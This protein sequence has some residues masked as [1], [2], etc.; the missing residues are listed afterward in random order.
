MGNRLTKIYTRTGD[1]GTTGLGDGSRVRKT[2]PRIESIGQV[3]H[4]N[5]L[6]G[7]VICQPGVPASTVKLLSKIQHELFD[8]GAE[9][10]V[11]GLSRIT[12]QHVER[13][14]NDL[15]QLNEGLGRLK[16]FIL[17]GGTV[18]AAMAHLART[19]CRTTE[20]TML[21]LAQEGEYVG[22]AV[23]RYLNRL[24]DLLFVV[25]RDLNRAA[26][27]PDVIWIQGTAAM[28]AEETSSDVS[29][30]ASTDATLAETRDE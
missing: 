12:D 11:P 22:P 10:C 4:L 6:I 28:P 9:L 13:L 5:A 30:A 24:S 23:L 15:D 20:R 1:D 2:S 8:M 29:A 19:S 26:G 27:T 7:T 25:A 17:P 3:D 21:G 14:E 16:D 18:A